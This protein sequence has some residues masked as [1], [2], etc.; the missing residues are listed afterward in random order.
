MEAFFVARAE[1]EK[2]VR[3]LETLLEQVGA[4]SRL[5]PALK[6]RFLAET[7]RGALDPSPGGDAVSALLD[8]WERGDEPALAGLVFGPLASDPTLAEFFEAMYFRRNEI[9][10][11]RL[12]DHLRDG[13]TR[14]CVVGVSHLVGER[15]VVALLRGWGFSV[16]R[17][18]PPAE[19]PSN[20]PAAPMPPPTQWV[21]RPRRPPLGRRRRGSQHVARG[22]RDRG[23]VGRPSDRG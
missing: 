1:G 17:I 18:A 12:G 5:S 9:M 2:P 10:A 13:R 11:R 22:R 16:E 4:L 6:E 15:S 20:G 7:L 19:A 8:A 23:R 3:G 14:F 21:A